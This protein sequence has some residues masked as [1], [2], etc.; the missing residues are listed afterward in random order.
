MRKTDMAETDD[1]TVDGQSSENRSRGFSGLFGGSALFL[2][3]A[4][5]Q[6]V[7]E[8]LNGRIKAVSD[9]VRRLRT[10]P[11]DADKLA[12]L[13]KI[14]R[15]IGFLRDV[16]HELRNEETRRMALHAQTLTTLDSI[17]SA[18]GEIAEETRKYE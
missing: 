11:E 10:G 9:M 14:R 2:W 12:L 8:V 16:I 4:G 7:S 17:Y 6:T 13:N 15:Q 3:R 1:G 18:I 5:Y